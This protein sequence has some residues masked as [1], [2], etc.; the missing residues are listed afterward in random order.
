MKQTFAV[1]EPRTHITSGSFSPMGWAFPAALGAKLARPDRQV[2][3][4]LGE[5]RE[6][7]W[8]EVESIME[9]F[10]QVAFTED[11]CER[12]IMWGN[13]SSY[14]LVGLQNGKVQELLAR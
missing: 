2:V 12:W 13:R 5:G 14:G 4:V 1:Y 6:V 7:P 11:T 10:P 8:A 9:N 3:A